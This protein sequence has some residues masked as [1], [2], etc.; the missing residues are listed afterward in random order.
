MIPTVQ[1]LRVSLLAFYIID[2][3]ITSLL[4]L[5]RMIF[6]SLGSL[7]GIAFFGMFV[8]LFEIVR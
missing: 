8:Q 6:G 1:L 2:R 5:S 3:A 7:I 4:L